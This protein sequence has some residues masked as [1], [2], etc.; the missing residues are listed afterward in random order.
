[1]SGSATA[2]RSLRLVAKLVL[3][4][5]LVLAIG[6]FA[7]SASAE[8]LLVK[9]KEKSSYDAAYGKVHQQLTALQ[10][11]KDQFDQARRVSQRTRHKVA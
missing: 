5:F 4:A 11:E 2:A 6:A 8:Y 10:L 7:Q 9:L 1:M 3:P